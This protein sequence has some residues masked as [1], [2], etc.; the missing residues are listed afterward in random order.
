MLPHFIHSSLVRTIEKHFVFKG[1]HRWKNSLSFQKKNELNLSIFKRRLVKRCG[2]HFMTLKGFP[3]GPD[4]FHERS[5]GW[6]KQQCKQN[7][8]LSAEPAQSKSPLPA[9]SFLLWPDREPS[10]TPHWLVNCQ[11][12]RLH[13]PASPR[14]TP[15]DRW[16]LGSGGICVNIANSPVPSHSIPLPVTLLHGAWSMRLDLQRNGI[17]RFVSQSAR[18]EVQSQ[19]SPPTSSTRKVAREE[20]LILV[21]FPSC[22]RC[23]LFIYAFILR[24]VGSDSLCCRPLRFFERGD[25]LKGSSPGDQSRWR[26]RCRAFRKRASLWM[27]M[28]T[29]VMKYLP[30][31][32]GHCSGRRSD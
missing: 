22:P 18:E 20:R 19:P 29:D 1:M 10:S 14:R 26:D 24:I 2:S 7:I 21:F 12:P 25:E 16:H 23:L 4:S 13:H 17:R 9:S 32:L 31:G 27:L 15:G 3:W 28:E 30:F 8:W 5:A 11:G 6:N